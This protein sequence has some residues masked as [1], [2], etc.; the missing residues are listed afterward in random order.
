M[1]QGIAVG[2]L[3][4]RRSPFDSANW[5]KATE[6]ASIWP[7]VM[8]ISPPTL[9]PQTAPSTD[10]PCAGSSE[11]PKIASQASAPKP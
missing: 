8:N 5:K 2:T 11:H 7:I 9:C 6:I 1:L 4:E 10:N 3:G